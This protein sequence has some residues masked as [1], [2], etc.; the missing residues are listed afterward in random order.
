MMV[1]MALVGSVAF[2]VSLAHGAPPT[3]TTTETFRVTCPPSLAAAAFKPDRVPAGWVGA[4]PQDTRV[5][6]AGLLW[7]P[8]DESGYL[9]PD[10]AK[11]TGPAGR[12]VNSTRWRLAVPH[13]YETWMYCAY[14]PL[15]L[16]KRIPPEATECTASSTGSSGAFDEVVFACK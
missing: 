6:G 4:V 15:Q 9:K 3:A 12:R 16:S 8:P 11:T 5:S 13:S 14:G 10:E 1:S 7:G 2:K